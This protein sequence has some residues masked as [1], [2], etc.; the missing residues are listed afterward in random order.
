MESESEPETASE[1]AYSSSGDDSSR[2]DDE[3]EE[4]AW[5]EYHPDTDRMYYDNY[6]NPNEAPTNTATTTRMMGGFRSS[7]GGKCVYDMC[8]CVVL[9]STVQYGLECVSLVWYCM[10]LYSMVLPCLS[11]TQYTIYTNIYSQ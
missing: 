8:V 2:A 9:Q 10:V 4:D 5:M 7:S 1:Y 6:N 3:E 11:L